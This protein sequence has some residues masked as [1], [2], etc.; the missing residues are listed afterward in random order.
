MSKSRWQSK[1]LFEKQELVLST[2]GM[3]DDGD[4][5]DDDRLLQGGVR[6]LFEIRV[7]EERDLRRSRVKFQQVELRADFQAFPQLGH[8]DA[9]QRWKARVLAGIDEIDRARKPLAVGQRVDS[10]AVFGG[11]HKEA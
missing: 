7:S 4:E 10:L 3:V 5:I 8:G 2:V 9:Q 1:A 11:G 6:V